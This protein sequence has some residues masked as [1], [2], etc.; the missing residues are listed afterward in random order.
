[1]GLRPEEDEVG[2]SE[3]GPG[4]VK[5]IR[6]AADLTPDARNA[7]R[8]TIRGR[9]LLVDSLREYG[10]GRSIVVDRAGRIIA[11]NKTL[12]Q[13]RALG[14]PVET[15][16]TEGD[17]LVVVQR[18]DLDLDTDVRARQLALADNRIAELDLDWDDDV[19]RALVEEG[20]SVEGLWSDDELAA[21]VGVPVHA[22]ENAVVA[23]R[24]TTIRRRQ[25]LTAL[26]DLRTLTGLDDPD[27][28]APVASTT[29]SAWDMT[30]L[31]SAELRQLEAM[32]KKACESIVD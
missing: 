16:R 20:V 12:A 4:R 6:Q 23:P 1:M 27:L 14:L 10:A 8:G 9:D 29:S 25:A 30:K 28:A 22:A 2:R 19:L 13:A 18:V 17:R 15:V 32:A 26:T 3:E 5:R 11:G 7:N 21:L 31:T 24:A